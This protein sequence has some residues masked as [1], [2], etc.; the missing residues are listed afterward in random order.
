MTR[1]GVLLL[2][3]GVAFAQQAPRP[4]QFISPEVSADRKVTFRLHYEFSSKL[5]EK[6]VGP[7]FNHI[8]STFIDSFVKRA[9]QS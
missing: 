4:P 3:A 1:A 5:L 7:V 9:L 2:L 6:V 8:A